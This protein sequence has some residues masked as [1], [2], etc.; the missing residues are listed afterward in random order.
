MYGAILIH[1]PKTHLLGTYCVAGTVPGSRYKQVSK[2]ESLLS[3]D[4]Q[5][6]FTLQIH[7]LSKYLLQVYLIPGT[8]VSVEEM[9]RKRDQ[10]L[11]LVQD[12]VLP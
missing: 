5:H 2:T 12:Q 6:S 10:V 9:I 8:I 4:N 1:S 11:D 3:R 7:L